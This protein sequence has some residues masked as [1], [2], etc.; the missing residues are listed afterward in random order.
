MEKFTKKQV[1]SGALWKI[2][3]Q[4][5]AK[6]ISFIVSLVLAR[7]LLPDDYGLIALTAVFTNFSDILIDSGFS[8][9]LVRKKDVDDYDY[10]SVFCVSFSIATA[11]YLVIFFSAPYISDFYGEPSLTA[12]LRVIGLT[13]FFQA[14]S[15]IR[16]AAVTRKMQF[17]LLFRCNC[18][19]TVCSGVVGI[20]SAYFGAGVWALVIQR[21]TQ[22]LLSTVLLLLFIKWKFIFKFRFDR[23]KEMMKFSSGVVASSFINYFGG[24]LYSLI[25]G[26]RYSVEDLG[27]YNKSS[28]LSMQVS[29]YTFG[30][31]SSVLLPTLASYQEDLER[32]KSIVRRVVSITAYL[33]FP[34]M[35]GLAMVS[36][37][38]VTL[39]YTEKW[40]PIVPMMRFSCLYYTAT[41]FM[42]I[43]VQV[44]FAL[45]RSSYRVKSE[46]ARLVMLIG[47]IL[48]FSIGLN[49]NVYYLALVCAVVEVL[50]VLVTYFYVRKMLNYRIK[51]YLGDLIVPIL[52]AVCMAIGIFAVDFLLS[53]VLM[54]DTILWS[55]I[56]KV[57]F[58][59]L[60]YLVLSMFLKIQGFNELLGFLKVFKKR[61]NG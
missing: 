58:G 16:I 18:I 51:E 61:R 8:T 59:V 40:L 5:S 41:P 45:G 56:F 57:L 37:E 23:L 25:I 14:F 24:S 31:M 39:L 33:I 49:Y 2:I 28:E 12:V 50:T 34:M 54:I 60:I 4:F 53:S 17:K 52:A 30:A 55:L 47:G 10:S 35:I 32:M 27:Y 22:Q 9:A 48:I 46:L 21:L 7:L 38:L 20:L 13:L 43:N 42:L 15:S 3:E 29:L 19:A 11:L 6:G 44:F 26:K 36:S 1:V